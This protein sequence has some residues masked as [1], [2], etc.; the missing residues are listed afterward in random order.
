MANPVPIVHH[1]PSLH[2]F[3]RLKLAG[4]GAPVLEAPSCARAI[5]LLTEGARP[6]AAV[7]CGTEPGDSSPAMFVRAPRASA[8]QPRVFFFTSL[9]SSL[10][11][12]GG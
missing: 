2:W 10:D 6:V 12:A 4:V 8:C 3:L 5:D 1:D 9:T 7:I 11:G